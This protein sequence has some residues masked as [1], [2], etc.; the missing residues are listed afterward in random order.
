MPV[1]FNIAVI[2]VLGICACDPGTLHVVRS[3]NGKIRQMWTEKGP[4]GQRTV[5]EGLFKSLLPDG[6]LESTIEY[7]D[8]MKNGDANFWSKDGHLSF[9]GRY[10]GDFLVHEKRFNPQGKLLLERFFNVKKTEMKALGPDGDSI[11]AGE[12]CAWTDE[13]RSQPLR[14]GLC[15]LTYANGVP[16]ADRYYQFGH[17]QG[18]VTAWFPD[19]K[20]WMAGVYER[21][22]PTGTWKTWT[23]GGKPLWTSNYAQGEK[24]GLSEEWFPD[25]KVKSKGY[26]R[27]GKQDGPYQEWYPNGKIRV[28]TEFQM[29]K[30]IGQEATWYPDG[31]K[32][33]SAAYSGGKLE[34]DFYQWYPGGPMRLHCRFHDGKKEGLSR[35]WYRQGTV[36]EQANFHQGR[37]N[38]PYRTW[39]PEGNPLSSKEFRDGTVAFDSKAKELLELLGADQIRVPVGLLG[40]YWGMSFKDCRSNLSLLQATN[41]HAGEDEITAHLVAFVDRHPSEAKVRVQFNAQGELWG[42]KLDVL[43]K[44]SGDCF[45]ICENLETEIGSELG[46][47]GLRKGEGVGQYYMTRKKAWGKFT[48]TTGTGEDSSAAISAVLPVVSAEAFSPGDKG[49]FRFSLANHLYREYANPA[50][51]EITPP[52]WPEE[53]FLAGR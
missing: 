40:F 28:Q 10:Q 49:W 41:I 43:Q 29:G 4:P 35:V 17:L 18:Q 37:L 36:L 26:Y 32:L 25:G 23:P 15:K 44:N 22:I 53:A 33:Y 3:S 1:R 39:G 21:D 46:T 9:Q 20:L 7:H 42:I 8:G 14:H 31:T 45:T 52:S 27:Q 34:G 11:L 2:S 13:K 51:A 24:N 38:G 48:V 30:R 50:N 12:T 47:T 6:R 19:G 16:L 5:R